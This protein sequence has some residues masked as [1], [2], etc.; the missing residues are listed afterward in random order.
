VT[1]AAPLPHAQVP[2]AEQLS[3]LMLSQATH[4]APL[5]PQA[6]TD[7]RLQVI[8]AASQQPV[9]HVAELH[10]ALQTVPWH[11]SPTQQSKVA[12]QD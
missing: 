9:G 10:P 6:L 11:A 5:T 8:V 12:L 3:A 7:F 1:H 4:G 2:D